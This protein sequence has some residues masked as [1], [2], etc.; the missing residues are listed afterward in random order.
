MR[1]ARLSVGLVFLSLTITFI[2]GCA[3]RTMNNVMSS[4]KGAPLEEAIQK[5]GYPTQEKVVA[6]HKLYL[7]EQNNGISASGGWWPGARKWGGGSVNIEYCNRILEVDDRGIIINGQ[8]D[9]NDC[10]KL[11]SEW[12]RERKQ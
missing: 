12:E 6:S 1:H 9:G 5:W 2:P 10:P 11:F 7:W 3:S 4:W 8:W